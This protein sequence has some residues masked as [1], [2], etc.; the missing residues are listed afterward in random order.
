[1]GVSSNGRR[2]S[3]F[4]SF[5][6]VTSLAFIPMKSF[7][8]GSSVFA[9]ANMYSSSLSSNLSMQIGAQYAA[10]NTSFSAMSNHI[11]SGIATQQAAFTNNMALGSMVI[12]G[13]G[14]STAAAALDTGNRQAAAATLSSHQNLTSTVAAANSNLIQTQQA[15][16][17]QRTAA[18]NEF[19]T[20]ANTQIY[21]A[22]MSAAET[23]YADLDKALKVSHSDGGFTETESGHDDHD[24]D[25]DSDVPHG[26][27]AGP[28]GKII[29][30]DGKDITTKVS[31]AADGERADRE[32][33]EFTDVLGHL[34]SF[35]G[36]DPKTGNPTYQYDYKNTSVQGYGV[37]DTA[38]AGFINDVYRV[39]QADARAF[40]NYDLPSRLT[41]KIANNPTGK[42]LL[43]VPGICD[44]CTP[45]QI[46]NAK[47][48]AG[49]HQSGTNTIAVGLGYGNRT[50]FHEFG[51]AVDHQIVRASGNEGLLRQYNLGFKGT[52]DNPAYLQANG[53]VAY[54][55]KNH[56]ESFAESYATYFV[57][58]G[59]DFHRGSV[60]TMD[61]MRQYN[62][63]MATA[64]EWAVNGNFSNFN[65]GSPVHGTLAPMVTG[66]I[67]S[68]GSV[69]FG[70]FGA[71]SVGL[72]GFGYTPISFQTQTA[73]LATSFSG[74]APYTNVLGGA[75]MAFGGLT[76]PT[77]QPTVLPAVTNTVASVTQGKT[78]QYNPWLREA[79]KKSPA[80][81]S[82]MDA[83][84]AVAD[85]GVL[86]FY[87][88]TTG[89]HFM[90]KSLSE[91][92]GA[93]YKFEGAKFKLSKV[94]G[95]NMKPLYR[96]YTGSHHFVS[97]RSDCEGHRGEGLYGYAS[98]TQVAGSMALHRGYHSSGD[99]LV[100]TDKSEIENA[101]Y[102]YQGILGYVMPAGADAQVAAK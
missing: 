14:T 12:A 102:G 25:H 10:Q 45:A 81:L 26:L 76:L 88:P 57:N 42:E 8:W 94:E 72:G 89:E 37:K 50:L 38:T 100:T 32:F 93:G 101:R 16:L 6:I 2:P 31:A 82:C 9:S 51:H 46:A 20:V 22:G 91:G 65:G 92:C 5:G 60:Q 67:M 41:V 3:L 56:H 33:K 58:G 27:P 87:M 69:S 52:V 83:G 53:E 75:K 55:G 24:H 30:F 80:T 7:A 23:G 74:F 68:G 40:A 98:K 34:K 43:S 18:S 99:S 19:F 79:E 95:E 62:P 48:A 61:D 59:S 90:T 54:N 21:S 66:N 44:H 71:P 4:V 17:E 35:E 11:S 85:H 96:C 28:E 49:Y 63:H 84:K 29:D 97:D 86:R 1:M 15:L 73:P 13:Q 70:G 64:V 36:F 77:Q 47:A 39:G 78:D